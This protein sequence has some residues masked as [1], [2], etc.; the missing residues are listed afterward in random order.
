M[1]QNQH[2]MQDT[3]AVAKLRLDLVLDP[4]AVE[5]ALAVWLDGLGIFRVKNLMGQPS[6]DLFRVKPQ[7]LPIGRVGELGPSLPARKT[8]C[9]ACKSGYPVPCLLRF[10]RKP[11]IGQR[12]PDHERLVALGRT[13]IECLQLTYDFRVAS[14]YRHDFWLAHV[15]EN[16]CAGRQIQRTPGDPRR[17]LEVLVAATL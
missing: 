13:A 17:S 9:N 2:A 6:C 8:K 4:F 10:L 16:D 3:R 5:R 7:P 14:A 12:I 15:V 11:R 1:T